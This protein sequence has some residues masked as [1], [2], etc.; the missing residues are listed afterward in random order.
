MKWCSSTNGLR[1]MFRPILRLAM[2]EKYSRYSAQ[3]WNIYD[4]YD[5]DDAHA[6]EHE[7]DN[8][9]CKPYIPNKYSDLFVAK[10]V[11]GKVK[12]TDIESVHF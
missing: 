10:D 6:H 9:V 1:E 12:T 3:S 5:D 2:G 8:V 4:G 7:D 11:T